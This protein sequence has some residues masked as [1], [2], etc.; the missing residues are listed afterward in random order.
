M[1]S[2]SPSLLRSALLYNKLCT[3]LEGHDYDAMTKLVADQLAKGE[4]IADLLMTDPAYN[5]KISLIF[6]SCNPSLACY[7]MDLYWHRV[8]HSYVTKE[9]ELTAVVIHADKL[10]GAMWSVDI[11]NNL[12]AAMI[13]AIPLGGW[14]R[15][16]CGTLDEAG[17]NPAR[18]LHLAL[19][20]GS[21]LVELNRITSFSLINLLVEH[22]FDR[23][24][25]KE[26]MVTGHQYW[27]R[28]VAHRELCL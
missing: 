23:L 4:E 12:Q 8:S 21:S 28:A 18:V 16:R 22:V 26:L 10:L 20:G 25:V 13:D 24:P 2:L 9:L 14:S 3:L 7:L 5:L 11:P 19:S 1:P 27:K 15:Y 6:S 17:D